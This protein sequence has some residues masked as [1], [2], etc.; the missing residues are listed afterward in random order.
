MR[1][2]ASWQAA[3]APSRSESGQATISILSSS[4]TGGR[5]T[6]RRPVARKIGACAHA[7]GDP[8]AP[9]VEF[10]SALAAGKPQHPRSGKAG[11]APPGP[12]SR[13]AR[14]AQN[15]ACVSHGRRNRWRKGV[16]WIASTGLR[17]PSRAP[18]TMPGTGATPH[19]RLVACPEPLREV[20]CNQHL[21][22]PPPPEDRPRLGRG[23]VLRVPAGSGS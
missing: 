14:G 6:S 7:S 21:R 18:C 17:L 12:M 19:W 16:V 1:D 9:L 10:G 8:G 3:I 11:R 15:S 4:S 5:G 20:L 23:G 2:L 13:R 22:L